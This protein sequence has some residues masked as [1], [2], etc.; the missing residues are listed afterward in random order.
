MTPYSKRLK[1]PNPKRN[2][3]NEVRLAIARVGWEA[4]WHWDDELGTAA[5]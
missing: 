1:T 2:K 4:G 3:T 5:L